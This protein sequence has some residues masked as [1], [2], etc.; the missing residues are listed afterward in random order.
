MYA[1]LYMCVCVCV[2]VWINIYMFLCVFICTC[3]FVYHHVWLVACYSDANSFVQSELVTGDPNPIRIHVRYGPDT[4]AIERLTHGM[5]W[6]SVPVH[7][8]KTRRRFGS[9][10][11]TFHVSVC[12]C[13]IFLLIIVSIIYMLSVSF[14]WP[15]D[16][17]Y[18]YDYLYYFMIY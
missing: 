15:S 13:I 10:I 14:Q 3:V 12:S 11:T 17:F 1:C 2:G 5:I 4:L 8:V 6:R 7:A 9:K 18:Q 16:L